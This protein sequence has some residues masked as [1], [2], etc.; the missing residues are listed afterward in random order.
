[1]EKKRTIP[2]G[3]ALALAFAAALGMK[4]FLFDFMIAEGRSML[5]GIKPGSLLLVNRAA[6]GLRLPGAGGYCI[7]WG[8]PSPGDVVVFYTPQGN[9]A[10]KRCA[11][12]IPEEAAP[13]TENRPGSAAVKRFFAQGDNGLE[14]FDSRSYGPIPVDRILGKVVGVK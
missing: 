12:L 13:A 9:M 7:R 14:S 2:L 3:A 1:M 8:L 11:G 6:Y 10:V 4:C 5:P